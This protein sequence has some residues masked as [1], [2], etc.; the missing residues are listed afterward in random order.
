MCKTP[1]NIHMSYT[2][3]D[4]DTDSDKDLFRHQAKEEKTKKNIIEA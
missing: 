4:T 2:D 1:G 3:S